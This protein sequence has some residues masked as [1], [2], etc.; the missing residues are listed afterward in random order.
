VQDLWAKMLRYSLGLV[1]VI[2]G[3]TEF[4]A[5]LLV[6]ACAVFHWARGLFAW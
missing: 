5:I 1:W 4:Y 2:Y 3:V 6:A